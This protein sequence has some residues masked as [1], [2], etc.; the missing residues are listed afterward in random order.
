MSFEAKVFNFDSNPLSATLAA[1]TNEA[2][3]YRVAIIANGN[4]AK[5]VIGDNTVNDVVMKTRYTDGAPDVGQAG[6]YQ[7]SHA[8]VIV[9]FPRV[10]ATGKSYSDQ[11]EIHVRKGRPSTDAEVIEMI[12]VAQQIVSSS[13][14]QGLVVDGKR[15]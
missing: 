3:T 2:P 12:A 10:D 13:E 11:M 15:S 4:G 9:D 8:R 14:F 1:G 7:P 5:Y 6:G